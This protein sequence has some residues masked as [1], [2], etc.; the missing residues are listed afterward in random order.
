MMVK[1]TP[2]TSWGLL[3]GHL[4]LQG[5]SRPPLRTTPLCP[6]PICRVHMNSMELA[7]AQSSHVMD[8]ERLVQGLRVGQDGI[9]LKGNQP[10]PLLHPQA[11]SGHLYLGTITWAIFLQATSGLQEPGHWRRLSGNSLGCT[12]YD[13]EGCKPW[14]WL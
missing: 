4:G 2:R 10:A 3:D 11:P 13:P 9:F 12:D 5:I 7:R 8:E 14:T 1:S 6:N